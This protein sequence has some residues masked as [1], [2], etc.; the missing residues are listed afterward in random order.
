M[1]DDNDDNDVMMMI[2]IIIITTMLKDS[3]S[4]LWK[5]ISEP[6]GIVATTYHPQNPTR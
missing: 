1:S 3:A 2:I 4:L 5:S 6:N